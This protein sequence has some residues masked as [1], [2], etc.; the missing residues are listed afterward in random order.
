MLMDFKMTLSPQ[1]LGLTETAYTIPEV[2]KITRGCRTSVYA[3]AKSGKIR[4]TK[5]GRKSI[6]LAID[7]AEFLSNLRCG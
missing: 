5:N 2:A 6:V 4:I 1:D 3:A 7:L